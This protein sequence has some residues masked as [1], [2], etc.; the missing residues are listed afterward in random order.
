MKIRLG[1]K[2]DIPFIVE[3]NKAMAIET[4][5]KDLN[6]LTLTKGVTGLFNNSNNG[7]YL[8]AEKNNMPCG[9]LMITKEWS[10]WR[11][12]TFWWIQSVYIHP[13]HRKE[14]IYK[15][16]HNEVRRLAN[17]EENI[18]GIRLY[19]DQENKNAKKVY[20]AMGMVETDYQLFE[21]D[22]S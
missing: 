3:F 14:G 2:E 5:E 8:I 21:E 1:T 11:N 22:W 16:L 17:L 4:E 19:V 10:D 9:Q 7:F 20:N 15:M 18:C 6:S 13:D 12:G